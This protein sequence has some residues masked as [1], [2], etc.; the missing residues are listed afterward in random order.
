MAAHSLCR[1]LQT[2]K[3]HGEVNSTIMALVLSSRVV[4]SSLARGFQPVCLLLAVWVFHFLLV[5]QRSTASQFL[6][7]RLH[8]GPAVCVACTNSIISPVVCSVH[9]WNEMCQCWIFSSLGLP[10]STKEFSNKSPTL[11]SI[12]GWVFSP[13]S[14][15]LWKCQTHCGDHFKPRQLDVFACYSSVLFTYQFTTTVISWNILLSRWR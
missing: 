9:H 8:Y 14:P 3:R 10:A 1:C 4:V 13:R 15:F 7:P 6:Q 12:V 5:N 2:K 11:W